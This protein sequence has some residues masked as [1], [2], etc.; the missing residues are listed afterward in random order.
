MDCCFVVVVMWCHIVRRE[1]GKGR[2]DVWTS[3]AGEPVDAST[4][5]LVDLGAT[6]EI[7]VLGIRVRNGVDGVARAVGCHVGSSVE[8]INAE[9]L[10][11]EFSK[12]RL[13]EMDREMA[14]VLANPGESGAEEVVHVTHKINFEFGLKKFLK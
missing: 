12:G 11:C 14:I 4:D 13:T 10:T 7:R 6:L 3:A 5:A 1:K 8:F 9:A 2:K